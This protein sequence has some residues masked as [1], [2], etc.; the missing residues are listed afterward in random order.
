MPPS[1]IVKTS[2]A[3]PLS[4]T[5]YPAPLSACTIGSDENR[6]RH[7]GRGSTL[8]RSAPP[9]LISGTKPLQCPVVK[10]SSSITIGAPQPKVERLK[11]FSRIDG[12]RETDVPSRLHRYGFFG[13]AFLIPPEAASGSRRSSSRTSSAPRSSVLRPPPSAISCAAA[14]SRGSSMPGRR[15][16]W[17]R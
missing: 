7:R 13:F 9:A 5:E 6:R 1:K 14:A 3:T 12:Q 4:M 2:L 8:A 11:S 10:L 15:I 16:W 17:R